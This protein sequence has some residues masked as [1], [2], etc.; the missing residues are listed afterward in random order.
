MKEKD[1]EMVKYGVDEN[2]LVIQKTAGRA[3]VVMPDQDL[4]VTSSDA[5]VKIP[6][7][8]KRGKQ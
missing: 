8:K 5:R 3:D 1:T 4:H 2:E 6:W 7:Q